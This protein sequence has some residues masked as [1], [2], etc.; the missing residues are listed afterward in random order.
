[1]AVAHAA[2]AAGLI[3]C[4]SSDDPDVSL[5][6][7]GAER[8]ASAGAA[9]AAYDPSCFPDRDAV[10]GGQIDVGRPAPFEAFLDNDDLTLVI[11]PQGG[12]HIDI[13]ARMSGLVPG[14][15]DNPVSEDNPYT[16]FFAY[17]QDEVQVS[18]IP[19]AFRI[20]YTD[21]GEGLSLDHDVVLFLKNE[22][23]APATAERRIGQTWRIGVEIVDAQGRYASDFHD[24]HVAEVAVS[25]PALH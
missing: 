22:H 25:N 14:D 5:D 8:D 13:Q 23:V 15:P 2:L 7:S 24:V 1:M 11:G 6:A 18:A 20:A 4:G 9:D 17:D 21:D 12:V 3:A 16:R 10:P 19:C